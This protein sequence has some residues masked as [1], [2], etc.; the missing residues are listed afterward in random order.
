MNIADNEFNPKIFKG[1]LIQ[2][3][4]L[5]GIAYLKDFPDKNELVEKYNDLF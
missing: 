4:L 1:L 3:K 2:G 5:E